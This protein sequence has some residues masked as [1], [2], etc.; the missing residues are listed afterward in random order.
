MGVSTGAGTGVGGSGVN[1]GAVVGV[2]AAV[3]SSVA[4][5]SGVGVASAWQAVSIKPMIIKIDQRFIDS[6]L[7]GVDSAP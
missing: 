1:V 3:G 7:P 6:L 5:G 4:V 2:G